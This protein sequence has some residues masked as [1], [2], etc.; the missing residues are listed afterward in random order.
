M[1]AVLAHR[2]LD[3]TREFL[4]GNGEYT[5]N[6]AL[7]EDGRPVLGLVGVPGQGRVYLGWVPAQRALCI[8]AE[9]LRTALRA[10]PCAT[11]PVVVASRRHRGEALESLLQALRRRRR[12]CKLVPWAV[13]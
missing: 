6:V 10:R 4:A 9:G 11:P 13:R 7:I 12:G 2:P 1:V 3:G 8:T 5:V